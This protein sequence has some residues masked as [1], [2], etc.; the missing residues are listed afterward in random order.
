MENLRKVRLLILT[1][2]ILAYRVP[3]FS[4]LASLYD[5]TVAYSIG[6]VSS[7]KFPFKTLKL[8]A[9]KFKRFVVQKGNVYKLAKNF[10]VI[11]YTGD[12]AW[13]KYSTLAFRKR[14]F[15]VITW[16]IGVSAS[17]DK[18]YDSVKRWDGV[19][20]FFY[21]RCD[22]I[23]FYS[24]YPIAKY[25]QR[26]FNRERLF[27]AHNTVAVSDKLGILTKN[28][29]LFVG[30]LYR[31]K[32][33]FDLLEAYLEAYRLNKNLFPLKIVGS[34]EEEEN[35]KEFI[36]NHDLSHQIFL[37]GA[38]Y[39]ELQKEKLFK[40]AYA[41]I[42]PSQAGLGVL[43]S[44]AHGTPFITMHTAITGGERFNIESEVNGLLYNTKEDLVNIILDICANPSYYEKLGINALNYYNDNRT[45]KVMIQGF[46][47]AIN[48]VLEEK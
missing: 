12:I 3:I 38:I 5:L 6:D 37:L 42:S 19:R 39:D 45:P 33:I 10:D 16:S 43:E 7:K 46:V 18:P 8:P 9:L 35:I 26:G 31:Q 32:G 30:T 11:I 14:P 13:L 47:D 20:D 29:I 22:A 25:V 28:S 17:Y 34:G 2:K 4:D 40:E 48:S 24:D 41:C 36:K 44:M 15:K 1:N 27:V 23:L 21:K